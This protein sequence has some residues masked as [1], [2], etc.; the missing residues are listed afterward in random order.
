MLLRRY[1]EGDGEMFFELIR[2]E[3]TRL[4][5]S[6][7]VTVSQAPDLRSAEEHIQHLAA[8]W[9][10]R[11]TYAF[12]LLAP[13]TQQYLGYLAIK[14]LNWFHQHG[15]LA[16]FLAAHAEGQGLMREAIGRVVG[17]A[18]DE[19]KLN[20]LYIRA[21]VHNERSRH[22]ALACGFQEEGVLKEEF[23]LPDGR[24]TD[25]ACYGLTRQ[26]FEASR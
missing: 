2:R 19:L 5:E 14:N 22:L 21:F 26:Q 13:D 4:A 17:F 20:R 15:E 25:V 8:Q 7:P 24:Y 10:L 16:Y 9:Y 11:K 1:R 12:A 23:R 6:F 18:W 3:R